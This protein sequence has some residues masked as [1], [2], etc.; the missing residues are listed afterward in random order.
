MLGRITTN[1]RCPICESLY[2][3]NG[4]DALK[5]P[6]HPEQ[7]ATHFIVK[8]KIGKKL[9]SS[10]NPIEICNH[11]DSY[12]AAAKRLT[13]IRYE[14]DEG[15]FDY[16]NYQSSN[17]LGF[18]NLAYKYISAR[19]RKWESKKAN[20][21]NRPIGKSQLNNIRNSLGRAKMEWGNKNIIHIEC[22]EI[23]DFLDKQKRLDNPKIDISD[24]T[25]H[26]IAS[27]LHKFWTWV[28]AKEKLEIP[29]FPVIDFELGWRN[30]VDK[31][32]QEA[33]LDEI[34][35]ISY[36]INPRIYICI[37][38]LATYIAVRPKE[39]WLLKEKDAIVKQDGGYLSVL[40][41]KSM[42]REGKL[43]PVF[44]I[45]EDLEIIRSLPH[46]FPEMPFFRHNEA[47]AKRG[48][49][50][51]REGERFG[52]KY[53][54]KWWKR[55]CENLG[56]KNVDLYGGTKHSSVTALI[57]EEGCSPE[58]AMQGTMHEQN[59]AF[60]RYYQIPPE[61]LKGLYQ[62][63]RKRRGQPDQRLISDPRLTP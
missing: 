12:R 17:P 32:H 19:E 49:G 11:Y 53:I 7:Q 51:A 5:C 1:Q 46:G 55:A 25:R 59:K 15:R 36:H 13:G 42:R 60:K 37:K 56:I 3:D 34:H 63:T 39:M 58:E 16:R 54:Y 22:D 33:I 4:H 9:T 35:R 29:E 24:K 20:S 8:V 27:C 45:D 40:D 26:E 6:D 2:R 41:S 28:S 57:I 52:K 18:S 44:L 48:G 23:D 61:H 47:S 38:W 31:D 10:D 50:R 43:K 21:K 14:I 30:M 62:K